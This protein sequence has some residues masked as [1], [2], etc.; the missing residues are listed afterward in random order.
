MPVLLKFNS[1]DA[2]NK[3][4]KLG[5]N[6]WFHMKADLTTRKERILKYAREQIGQ[7][8]SRENK[9]IK[10]VYADVN[11]ML[12]AFTSNGRFR[13]FNSEAEFNSLLLY[14]ENTTRSSEC[15]Y[16]TIGQDWA[17]THPGD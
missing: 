6:S 5:K 12:M 11:C 14:I 16:D 17:S 9:I 3:M 8:S 15:I 10:Y 7:E 1:W 13:S 2:R 4:Y